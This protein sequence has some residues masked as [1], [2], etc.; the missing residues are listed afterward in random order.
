VEL[1][2]EAIPINAWLRQSD[3]QQPLLAMVALLL[4]LLL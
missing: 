2:T 3:Q 4:L 1:G